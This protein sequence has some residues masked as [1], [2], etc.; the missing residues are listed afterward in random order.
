MDF[1]LVYKIFIANEAWL[2]ILKGLALT[3]QIT[4]AAAALGTV[5]G[6][7]VCFLRMRKNRFVKSLAAA[8]IALLQGSPVLMLLMLL[9]YGVFAGSDF[10]PISVAILAF[11][12]HTS[13]YVAEIIRSAISATDRGQVEA[14]RTLGFSKIQAFRFVTLP[15]LWVIARP[16]YKSAIINLLQWTSVVGYISITDLTRVIY[17]TT[18]RTMQPM[19]TILG[20]MIIYLIVTYIIYGIFYLTERGEGKNDEHSLRKR[21]L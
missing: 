14:A 20:G 3:A 21:A 13:A 9:F 5:L 12:M 6:A 8:Y 18:S 15:Q 11:S 7:I 2:T 16:V 4:V 17:N 19:I 1:N 10:H